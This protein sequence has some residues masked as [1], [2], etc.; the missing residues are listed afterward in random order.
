MFVVFYTMRIKI[1][2]RWLLSQCI[3][4][5]FIMNNLFVLRII[6]MSNMQQV[7]VNHLLPDHAR[8]FLMNFNLFV[9]DLSIWVWSNNRL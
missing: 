2:V 9:S 7:Q 6:C 5:S 4:K 1:L 8:Y 3:L